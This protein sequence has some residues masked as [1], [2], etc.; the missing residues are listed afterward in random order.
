MRLS[1]ALVVLYW[2]NTAFLSCARMGLPLMK[3]QPIESVCDHDHTPGFFQKKVVINK[4]AK[5]TRSG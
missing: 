2:K 5:E 3:T 4:H 1:F